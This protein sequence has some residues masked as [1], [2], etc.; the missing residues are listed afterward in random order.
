MTTQQQLLL[1]GSRTRKKQQQ[2]QQQQQQQMMVWMLRHRCMVLMLQM[3]SWA[4][5]QSLLQY[6]LQQQLLRLLPACLAALCWLSSAQVLLPLVAAL[7]AALLAHSAA[8]MTA[9]RWGRT[10]LWS[11]QPGKGLRRRVHEL[12]QQQQQPK[13]RRKSLLAPAWAVQLH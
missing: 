10:R 13:R 4:K 2:Q 9:S 8:S 6:L 7:L 5:L 1:M 11:L 12:Q 3:Q